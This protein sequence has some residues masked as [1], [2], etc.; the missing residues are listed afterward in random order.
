MPSDIR[1]L[2]VQQP[3]AS[4]IMRGH[5]PVENR[6]WPFP[7]AVG[8]VIGIHAGVRVDRHG[9]AVP[10][11]DPRPR[12]ERGKNLGVLLGV[13]RV[14]GDHNPS[15]ACLRSTCRSWGDSSAGVRH[16]VLADPVP[17][18]EPVAMRGRLTLFNPPPDVLPLLEAAAARM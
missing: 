6:T 13:V 3:H 2:T 8:A 18:D 5:K 16:W 4:A 9:L 1:V 7:L 10:Q 12:Y 15:P 11:L 17:L 14:I